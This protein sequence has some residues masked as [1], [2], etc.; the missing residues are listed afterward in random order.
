MSGDGSERDAERA[1]AA[2]FDGALAAAGR[3]LGVR[4]TTLAGEEW[5][6]EGERL[7]VGREY[8]TRRGHGVD[9]AVA[10]TLRELWFV[11]GAGCSPAR[12]N[13]RAR[14]LAARPDLHTLMVTLD[15]V[16]AQRALLEA[17]P[18]FGRQLIG[19][20]RR[21]IPEALTSWPP[22][23]QWLGLVQRASLGLPTQV[24]EAVGQL[25]TPVTRAALT[26]T[27]AADPVDGL[28]RLLAAV[29]PAYEALAAGSG[30]SDAAGGGAGPPQEGQSG[31]EGLGDL[32]S[33]NAAGDDAG[34]ET[35]A[36]PD[37][38][39]ADEQRREGDLCEPDPSGSPPSAATEPGSLVEAD[40]GRIPPVLSETPLPAQRPSLTPPGG[41]STA[42]LEAAEAA[43][44]GQAAAEA[45]GEWRRGSAAALAEYRHCLGTYRREIRAV[46]DVWRRLL[47]E[48]LRVAQRE[49]RFAG[50]E[51]G[52]IHTGRLA[53][54]VAEARGGDPRP[55][56]Y[57]A[58][59]PV[60]VS[61]PGLGRTDTVLVLD[62]SGSMQGQAAQLSADAAMVFLEALAG[63]ARELRELETRYPG[64][65]PSAVRSGLVVFDS[66]ATLVKR[67][68]ERLT[69]THRIALR[70]AMVAAEGETHPVPAIELAVRELL[71][72]RRP[73]GVAQRRVL[74]FVSDGGF[75]S[76][77]EHVEGRA[78]AR[79]LA[80]AR[81]AGIEVY[82]V[83]IG[84]TGGMGLFRPGLT[85]IGSVREL[86]AALAQML[87]DQAR[88]ALPGQG[89]SA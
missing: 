19:A 47:R 32:G 12:E 83:G 48:S 13:R 69:D 43:T 15:R 37:R 31:V 16:Q 9:A 34:G 66:A 56:V 87:G 73:A 70:E 27:G 35:N 7:A 21:D 17:Q 54:T 44:P 64:G 78:L 62:R 51:P 39:N 5:R 8:F 18:G 1:E 75:A 40:S 80:R 67:C 24:G 65:E 68:N 79:E 61:G 38:A 11:T 84:V 53:A 59:M 41:G 29:A 86:P 71:I 42:Q 28:D 45:G 30:L 33:A 57:R 22:N 6:F 26:G 4:V 58:R 52:P 77:P 88:V 55:N 89:G 10:L 23:A 3:L 25:F 14:V 63:A 85:L 49:T 81:A 74:V 46:G 50:P 2:E 36:D 20:V 82:G 60:T 72:A 76:S